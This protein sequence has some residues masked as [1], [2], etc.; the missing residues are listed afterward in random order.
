MGRVDE[1]LRRAAEASAAAQDR[2]G[3]ATGLVDTAFPTETAPS[4]DPS[5]AD[6][7]P[8]VVSEYEED[9]TL[10]DTSAFARRADAERYLHTAAD[11]KKDA[12][13][14]LQFSTKLVGDERSQSRDDRQRRGW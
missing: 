5:T 12:A 10:R 11:P 8:A 14:G 4:E 2:V 13:V 3:E 7:G 9:A 1:A 6:R